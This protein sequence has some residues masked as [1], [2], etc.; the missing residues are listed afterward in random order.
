MANLNID[1]TYKQIK[2]NIEGVSTYTY[3][4]LGTSNIALQYTKKGN[5]EIISLN[6]KN[7]SNK[8]LYA[9]K[10]SL[11][12]LFAFFPGQSILDPE[13][14]NTLYKYI[15]QKIDDITQSEIIRELK[16]III[17]YQPR[18]QLTELTIQKQDQKL[19]YNIII[20]YD[21]PNLGISSANIL[22][23]STSDGITFN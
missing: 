2:Q 3:R 1:L 18:I 6:D 8:D 12:N 7:S 17:K 9:I 22:S 13:Y 10:Q 5:K 21:I 4:D 16:K 23:L 14:G 20:K 15:Y 11:R 19:A